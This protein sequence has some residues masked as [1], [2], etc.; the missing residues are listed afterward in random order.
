MQLSRAR[1]LS[2]ASTTYHGASG[3]SVWTNISS[4]AREKST[5]RARDSRSIGESFQ[6]RI[7]SSSR[8]RK[9]RSCSSSLTENQYFTAGSRP[10]RAAARRSGT[11]AGSGGTRPACR[12][13]SRARRRRG[14]TSCGRRGR[15]RRPPAGARRSAGSTTASRSRSVGAGSATMRATRGLRYSVIRLIAPPLPAASRPSKTITSRS[16]VGAHPLLQL[17]ELGL[18]PQQ[19]RLVHL[20]RDPRR[21]VVLHVRS[22]RPPGAR[23]GRAPAS[24]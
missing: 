16:P 6:R 24:F 15:S 13:P 23:T 22:L 12:S 11:G 19:L 7:G 4:F 21:L 14:C 18:Q 2:S 3:M 10:R 17:H 1:R 8:E 20:A 9:R 5:Q